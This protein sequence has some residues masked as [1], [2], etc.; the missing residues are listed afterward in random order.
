MDSDALWRHWS[1]NETVSARHWIP[2]YKFLIR[3]VLSALKS[4]LTI[5]TSIDCS[6]PLD[7]K[8]LLLKT[9]FTLNGEDREIN[10]KWIRK[11][12]LW[13][14]AYKKSSAQGAMQA[15]GKKSLPLTCKHCDAFTLNVSHKRI[16]QLLDCLPRLH[17]ALHFSSQ[18]VGNHEQNILVVL[19]LQ[20]WQHKD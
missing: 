9:L 8:I 1:S 11:L 5:T 15:A 20:N 16:A 4:A 3:K 18:I 13:W 12:S 19:L 6:W 10:L 14:L 17:E 2:P 7:G